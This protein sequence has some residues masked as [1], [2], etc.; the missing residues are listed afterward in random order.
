MYEDSTLNCKGC[1]K[2]FV[3]AAS[4]RYF[5]AEKG[6]LNVPKRCPECRVTE[7]AKRQGKESQVHEVEC[8]ECHTPTRVPFKPSGKRPVL[9]TACMHKTRLRSD[10]A[11]T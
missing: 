10:A 8:E 6:L 9:C 3:F 4:E 7:R 2:D 1:G 5:F 11:A